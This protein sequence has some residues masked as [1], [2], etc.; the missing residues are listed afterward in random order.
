MRRDFGRALQ[1][2]FTAAIQ[3]ELGRMLKLIQSSSGQDNLKK[4]LN[5]TQ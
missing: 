1:L 4:T 3:W 2:N 5:L